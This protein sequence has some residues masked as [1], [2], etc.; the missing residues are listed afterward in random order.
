MVD[1]ATHFS[2]A[3]F[4][5]PLTTES[6]QETILTLWATVYTGLPNTLV[7]DDGSQ[8]RDTFVEICEIHDVEWKRSGTQHHSALVILEIYHEPKRR[9]FQK[10]RIDHRKLK[11]EFLRSLAVKP[12]NDTIGPEGVVPSA[13]VFGE[14]TSL[15]S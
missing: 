11:K 6:V 4:V 5:E 13:L 12:C 14:F 1:D 9:T 7:F 10:L 3:Q 2:V 8:F 15:C